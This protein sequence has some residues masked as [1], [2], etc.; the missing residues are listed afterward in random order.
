MGANMKKFYLCF[1][2]ALAGCSHVVWEKP[3]ATQAD[4]E[5]D[6]ARCEYE[7]TLGT[8]STPVYSVGGAIGAGIAEGMRQNQLGTLCMR[9]RGYSSRVVQDQ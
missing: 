1:A 2:F 3:G 4:F 7:A 9:A 6:R 8:P 5:L